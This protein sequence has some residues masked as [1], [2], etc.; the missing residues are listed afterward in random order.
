MSNTASTLAAD[1]AYPTTP[2]DQFGR[3][4]WS[5]LAYLDVC[6]SKGMAGIG[7]IDRA[8]LRAHPDRHPLLAHLADW[9]DNWGTRLFGL[10]KDIGVEDPAVSHAS[11]LKLAQHDDWD[12]IDDLEEAGYIETFT[13]ANFA[14]Q[15]TKE[16]LQAARDLRAH[17]SAGGQFSN[18][19]REVQTAER[20]RQLA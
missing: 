11:G 6:C 4:H 15:L 12:C 17:K 16:G 9:N 14:V 8:K 2:V 19:Q 13:R 1:A 7:Q 18:F 3:D 10:G 5:L 20:E